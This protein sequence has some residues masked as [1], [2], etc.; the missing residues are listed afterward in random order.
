MMVVIAKALSLGG[1]TNMV[2]E[3]GARWTA[4]STFGRHVIISSRR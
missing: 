3:S 2:G 1:A 4:F